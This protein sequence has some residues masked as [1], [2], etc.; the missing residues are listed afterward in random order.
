MNRRRISSL[1]DQFS[2]RTLMATDRVE[3]LVV[4]EPDR[5]EATGP[6]DAIESEPP[7]LPRP[8]RAIRHGPAYY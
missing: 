3:V 4:G 2:A 6:Q 1:C 7:D 5:G 8:P